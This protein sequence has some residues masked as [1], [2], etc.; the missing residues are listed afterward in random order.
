MLLKKE[1]KK[2]HTL[3]ALI[4]NAT[5]HFLFPLQTNCHELCIA[6]FIQLKNPGAAFWIIYSGERWYTIPPKSRQKQRPQRNR[7]IN[8]KN[9]IRDSKTS[10]EIRDCSMNQRTVCTVTFGHAG[11]LLPSTGDIW[12]QWHDLIPLSF[13]SDTLKVTVWGIASDQFGFHH[14]SYF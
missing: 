1:M 6:F 5:L 10:F 13:L 3:L 7:W 12:A 4:N 8:K 9:I 14:N 11:L 2:A